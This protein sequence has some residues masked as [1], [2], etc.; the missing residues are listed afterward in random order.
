MTTDI[1][2]WQA[3][4]AFPVLSVL[5][6]LPLLTCGAVLGLKGWR[7]WPTAL[8]GAVLNVVLSIYLLWVFDAEAP[9]IHLPR[10]STAWATGSASTAPIFCSSR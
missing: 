1:V 2:Y 6:A 10:K 8:T 9:G 4:A 5:T 3:A 7:L